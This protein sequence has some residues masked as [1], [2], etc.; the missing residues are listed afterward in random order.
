MDDA[1]GLRI[2]GVVLGCAGLA[3]VAADRGG[4]DLFEH[5][6]RDGREGAGDGVGGGVGG[7]L[8]EGDFVGAGVLGALVVG[9]GAGDFAVAGFV[10]DSL[11]S[12][13][14]DGGGGTGVGRAVATG[15]GEVVVRVGGFWREC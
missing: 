14:G 13:R 10:V 12:G 9:G 11:H 5:R 1:V 4:G 8:D 6:L 3:G 2:R 15:V 7:V